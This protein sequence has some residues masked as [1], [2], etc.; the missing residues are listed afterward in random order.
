M[1]KTILFSLILLL[2]IFN[3]YSDKQVENLPDISR[4][5]FIEFNLPVNS[6]EKPNKNR[7]SFTY[8]D[9]DRA[10]K[11]ADSI[12]NLSLS[13]RT[14]IDS[15]FLVLDNY[16]EIQLNDSLENEKWIGICMKIP[17]MPLN[18]FSKIMCNIRV[19]DIKHAFLDLRY[20]EFIVF[21][22]NK[23]NIGHPYDMKLYSDFNEKEYAEYLKNAD[24][25]ALENMKDLTKYRL[26]R[27]IF[28]T[29]SSAI[30][31]SSSFES[32]TV[33]NFYWD[34]DNISLQAQLDSLD[35]LI[36]DFKN[37]FQEMIPENNQVG[38]LTHPN[39][40]RKAFLIHFSENIPLTELIQIINI[41]WKYRLIYEV[42]C[43]ENRLN[44]YTL[45]YKNEYQ[46]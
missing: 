11:N 31:L 41:P 5:Y 20:D 12:I 13:E 6:Y 22:C 19:N 30:I 17:Q 27:Y 18:I 26:Y 7:V 38:N 28:K 23:E 16:K 36:S 34:N 21:F 39:C 1:Q 42:D 9:I 43:V 40:N 2:S 29:N 8:Y 25:D 35:N 3:S 14:N 24:Y 44:I 33:V 45:C 10:K 4:C 37:E 46:N 32:E 15:L